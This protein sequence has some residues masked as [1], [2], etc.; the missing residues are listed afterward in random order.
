[1]SQTA[2]RSASPDCAPRVWPMSARTPFAEGNELADV[3]AH[4]VGDAD[5]H[6]E[7]GAHT[8]AVGGLL[9]LLQIAVAVGDG[10][11]LLVEIGG[12]KDDVGERGGL[13]EEHVLHDD[14]GVLERGGIDAVAGDGVRADDVER[15]ELALGGG[16]E[17][18]EHVEAGLG[19][20]GVLGG[21]IVL[22]ADGNVAGEHVGEQAHVGCA[23]R[24]GVVGEQANLA[25][26]RVRPKSMSLLE[27]GA[28]Q[29][30]ADED[31]ELL[32]GLDGV[33]EG[34]EGVGVGGGCAGGGVVASEEVR[35]GAVAEGRELQEGLGLAAELDGLGV[36]DVEARA[37]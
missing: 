35:E 15:G 26:G 4:L 31:E 19:G 2:W 27:L 25:P 13:G 14:E 7:V 24:V 21:E 1:M 17:D 5:D 30:G 10:A 12:G 6:L 20:S 9:H 3:G 33:A 34:G 11:G 16:V 22:R 29:L 18:L 32:F 8:G 28:A 23:A 37:C 36:G